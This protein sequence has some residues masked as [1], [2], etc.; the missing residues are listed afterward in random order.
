[1]NL[2]ICMLK[3]SQRRVPTELWL[4]SDHSDGNAN[5][6]TRESFVE[7]LCKFNWLKLLQIDFLSNLN[8]HKSI[9]HRKLA[10]RVE[11]CNKFRSDR[12]NITPEGAHLQAPRSFMREERELENNPRQ[13][14]TVGFSENRGHGGFGGARSVPL[15]P[16]RQSE[17]AW[18]GA[19][20]GRAR[21]VTAAIEASRGRVARM[22]SPLTTHHSLHPLYFPTLYY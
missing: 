3:L 21:Y 12:R 8:Q 5:R 15:A 14:I 11:N 6:S 7:C 18:A 17:S 10:W 19:G 22:H 2:F 4:M 16:G 20:A 13:I 9:G 1:M